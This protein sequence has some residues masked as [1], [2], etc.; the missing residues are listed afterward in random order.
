[1]SSSFIA[2]TRAQSVLDV[3]EK[4]FLLMFRCLAKRPMGV[5]DRLHIPHPNFWFS[6]CSA[7]VSLGTLAKE[8]PDL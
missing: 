5:L 7:S 2:R 8:N 1:M 6:L 3:L 4:D